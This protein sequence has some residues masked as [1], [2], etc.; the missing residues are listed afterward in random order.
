LSKSLDSALGARPSGFLHRRHPLQM[1][2]AVMLTRDAVALEQADVVAVRGLKS[3]IVS[4]RPNL[5]IQFFEAFSFDLSV[6]IA[7]AKR[8]LAGLTAWPPAPRQLS[9]FSP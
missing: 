2:R 3:L 4:V 7:Q 6:G 8:N 5:P 9:S 1:S